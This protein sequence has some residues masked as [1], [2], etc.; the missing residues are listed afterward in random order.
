MQLA[1]VASVAAGT[2]LAKVVQPTRLKAQVKI[3]ETQ[4]KDVQ[5]GQVA[6]ID[7][8]NGIIPGRVMRVDPAVQNGTVTLDVK[9]EGRIAEGRAAGPERGWHHRNRA[10]DRSRRA[11]SHARLAQ[12]SPSDARNEH[13]EEHE[14]VEEATYDARSSCE[15]LAAFCFILVDHDPRS[16]KNL[17][18][19]C[20]YWPPGFARGLKLLPP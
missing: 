11:L 7:T 16:Y 17:I 12:E 14:T 20:S 4:A 5:I 13:R 19:L 9:L 6:S 2:I 8:R 10:L 18:F 3:P 15:C 1:S